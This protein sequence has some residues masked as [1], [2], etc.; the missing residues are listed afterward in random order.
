[1]AKVHKCGVPLRSVISMIGTPAYKLAKFLD[2]LIKP[3]IPHTYLLKSTQEFTDRLKEIPFNNGNSM[4]SFDAVSLFTNVPLA[5]TIEL[6]IDRL[7]DDDNCNAVPVNKNVFRKLMFTATQGLFMYDNKLYKQVDGVTMGSPLGPT[8]ANFFLGC[9]EEKTFA[10]NKKLL[11]KL[12]L[13]YIDDVY[14]V[15]DCDNDCLKFWKC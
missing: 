13:R 2:D 6:I 5:E 11:P 10:H 8:L 1:M 7:H 4:V 15:F 9:T 12:Y 3:L 14:A